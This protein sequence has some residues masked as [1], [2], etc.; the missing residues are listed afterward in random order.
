MSEVEDGFATMFDLGQVLAGA[1]AAAA[2]DPGAAIAVAVDGTRLRFT[3]GSPAVIASLEC[4]RPPAGET[5]YMPLE[6]L[7]RRPGRCDPSPLE[8]LRELRASGCR[9]VQYTRS[10]RVTGGWVTTGNSWIEKRQPPYDGP[11]RFMVLSMSRTHCIVLDLETGLGYREAPGKAA[12]Q[13]GRA[14]MQVICDRLNAEAPR[15]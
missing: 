15:P 14:T 4:E 11:D 12:L 10:V 3:A 5:T 8:F 9:R 13:A 2:A 7:T 1:E 6:P